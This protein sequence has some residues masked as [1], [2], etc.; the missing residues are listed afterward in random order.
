MPDARRAAGP[1]KP[2]KERIA[3]VN[4]R[5]EID[6][7]LAQAEERVDRT[8]HAASRAQPSPQVSNEDLPRSPPEQQGTK[9][10]G[11]QQS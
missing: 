2:L 3:S 7:T 11:D 8:A 4:E 1:G 9:G 10:P 5:E 6:E